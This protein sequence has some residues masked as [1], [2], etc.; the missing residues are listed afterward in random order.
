LKRLLIPPRKD[1]EK[2]LTRVIC[3]DTNHSNQ[4]M[5]KRKW[6][7][8]MPRN[9]KRKKGG[10]GAEVRIGWGSVN[11]D[12]QDAVIARDLGCSRERVRQKR[13]ELGVGRS[14]KWHQR[15]EGDTMKD[16]IEGMETEK[17]T[18]K[19]VAKAV[20]CRKSYALQCLLKSGKGYTR[21]DRRLPL[22]YDWSKA[23]WGMTDEEVAKALGVKNA[24]VVSQYRFRHNIWK[25]GP[26]ANVEEHPGKPGHPGHP[27]GARPE[28]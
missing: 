4:V 1:D 15:V 23:D 17:M 8:D 25:R 28:G 10:H 27:G 2:M 13:K 20:G 18:L 19:E 22:K 6:G 24:G 12:V 7:V 21:I 3:Y 5:F 16:V 14:P 11:W 26:K 9:K